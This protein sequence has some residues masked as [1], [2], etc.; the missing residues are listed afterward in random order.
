MREKKDMV[1][2]NKKVCA[3]YP[4][5]FGQEVDSQRNAFAFALRNMPYQAVLLLACTKY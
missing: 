3:S 2:L 5:S 1:K 4:G